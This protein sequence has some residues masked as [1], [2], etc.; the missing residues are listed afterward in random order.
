MAIALV[1]ASIDRLQ[2]STTLRL[3]KSSMNIFASSIKAS[4]KHFKPGTYLKKLRLSVA[5]SVSKPSFAFV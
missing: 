2:L 3:R 1:S 4:A 5:I